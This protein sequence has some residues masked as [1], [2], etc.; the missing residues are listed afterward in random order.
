M[1]F[2]L[3]ISIKP[4]PNTIRYGNKILLIGSCFTEHIGSSLEQ[5]KFSMLQNPN[6]ILFDP[7]SVSRSLNS[8]IRGKKY[9]ET[10][11]FQWNE[12]WHSWEHHSRFSHI[13]LEEA[14]RIV[15]ESQQ[16]A[17]EFLKNADWIIITLGSSF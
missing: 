15:N 14:V 12:V 11:F 5:L 3:P 1:E 16:Q 7:A 2:Q 17:H 4:L 13:N 8:Y 10:D 9:N 6:G